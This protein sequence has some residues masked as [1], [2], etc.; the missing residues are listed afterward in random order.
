VSDPEDAPAP[1]SDPAPSDSQVETLFDGPPGRPLCPDGEPPERISHYRL[2]GPLGH[3]GMGEVFLAWDEI[4]ERRVAIKR[5]R[6]GSTQSSDQRERF[7]REARAAGRLSHSAIVQIH[8]LILDRD[9]IVMEYVHGSTLAERLET[10][11]L[12]VRE[13]LRLAREIA[14]GLAAAHAAGLIHRDLKAENVIITPQGQ[15]KILDFGLVKPVAADLQDEALTRKGVLL[16]TYHSMSPEQAGGGQVDERSDLFSLGVLLYE[17]LSGIAPFR[18]DNP[19]DTLKRVIAD[20]QS[21]L[22][23]VR[24]DIPPEVS[25]LVDRLLAKSRDERP[26]SAQEAVRALRELEAL[27]APDVSDSVSEMITADWTSTARKRG[28]PAGSL[29]IPW[30][31]WY[32]AAGGVIVLVTLAM[33]GMKVPSMRRGRPL[34]VVALRPEVEGATKDPRLEDAAS[35]V[36]AF[37]QATL[38]SFEGLSLIDPSQLLHTDGTPAEIV[39]AGAADEVITGTVEPEGELARVVLNRCRDGIVLRSEVFRV[40]TGSSDLGL[41]SEAVVAPLRRLYPDKK[42]RPGTPDLGARDE[43]YAEFL[44]IKHD[45]DEGSIDLHSDLARLE[46]VL[47]SSPRFLE[48]RILAARISFYLYRMELDPQMLGNARQHISEARLLA[49][50]D[51]RILSL[52]FQSGLEQSDLKEAESTLDK[53]DHLLP[54]DPDVLVLQASLAEKQGRMDEAIEKLRTAVRLAPTWQSLYSLASRE[55]RTGQVEKARRHFDAILLQS[56]RN[57]WALE[58]RARIEMTYGDL[59]RARTIFADLARSSG[60]SRELVHLGFINFLLHDYEAAAK[61]YRRALGNKPGSSVGMITLDLADAEVEMN[62]PSEAKADYEKALRLLEDQSDI[63]RTSTG[64]MYEAQCL[65]RLGRA[66]DAVAMIQETLQKKSDDP[67]TFFDAALVY[68]LAGEQSSALVNAQKAL[69]KGLQPSWF[70]AYGCLRSAPAIRSLLEA[71]AAKKR[72][73]H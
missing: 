22:T 37:A 45:R 35:G 50:E 12:P 61:D 28:R 30:R 51:P 59:N 27:M 38:A 32:L 20:T 5:I 16:G 66:S 52:T 31:R 70:D 11:P 65:A 23:K 63:L 62:K 64:R 47:R 49:P 6:Q 40:R 21:P 71:T 46:K 33:V 13:S 15:A 39:K 7:H 18:G 2:E 68:T 56:P 67:L 72:S 26:H 1:G 43:D 69:E 34:R 9:A 17:M 29:S 14:E 24:S 4:L 42:P 73:S 55:A 57:V 10:G 60:Q 44:A 58:G 3:G 8:E 25:A 48:A 53:L 19:L 41:L 36:L 54:G